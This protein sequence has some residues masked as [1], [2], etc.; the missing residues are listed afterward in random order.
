MASERVTD[1]R[2]DTVSIA[3]SAFWNLNAEVRKLIETYWSKARR[4]GGNITF[5]IPIYRWAEI[6]ETLR[7][8]KP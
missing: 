5:E 7:R 8:L 4:N 2:I 1:F 6:N 3:E